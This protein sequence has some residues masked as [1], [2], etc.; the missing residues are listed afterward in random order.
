[1]TFLMHILSF[2][3]VGLLHSKTPTTM[4]KMS[5]PTQSARIQLAS[6]SMPMSDRYRVESVNT[7]FKKNILLTLAYLRGVET[8]GKDVDWDKVNQSFEYSFTLNSGETFT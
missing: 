4:A 3:L 5:T 1:M 7:V 2:L 6:H 8:P